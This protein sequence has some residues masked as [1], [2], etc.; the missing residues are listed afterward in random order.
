MQRLKSIIYVIIFV[1]IVSFN[2]TSKN[3]TI[4]NS[5]KIKWKGSDTY[6]SSYETVHTYSYENR[7]SY[8]TEN[9]QLLQLSSA[10]LDVIIKKQPIKKLHFILTMLKNIM[11]TYADSFVF[12]DLCL[13]VQPLKTMKTEK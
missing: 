2:L 7:K 3:F 6:G 11:L 9:F 8:E 13:C 10:A 1:D 4:V 5:H 12:C